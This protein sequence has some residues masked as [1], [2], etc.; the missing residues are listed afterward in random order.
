MLTAAHKE[1]KDGAGRPAETPASTCAESQA[2]V[3]S[4]S[5]VVSFWSPFPRPGSPLR[6]PPN[7]SLGPVGNRRRRQHPRLSLPHPQRAP[8]HRSADGTPR[9][10]GHLSRFRRPRRPLMKE[11]RRRTRSPPRG[12]RGCP[13]RACLEFCPRS[14]G[15]PPRSGQVPP[16]GNGW[17][18]QDRQPPLSVVGLVSTSSSPLLLCRRLK[19]PLSPLRKGH[20]ARDTPAGGHRPIA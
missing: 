12:R 13:R 4:V 8:C 6:K 9:D 15:A 7:P 10:G 3:G 20:Q 11:E 2:G 14:G 19:R 16:S 17:G 5:R 18:W 1:P